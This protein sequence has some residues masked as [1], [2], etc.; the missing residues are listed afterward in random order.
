MADRGISTGWS[1]GTFRPSDSVSRLAMA[2]FMYRFAGSPAFTAPTTSPFNDIA[3][4]ST[5][6][7]E[8]AWV[9]STGISTG[10]ADGGYHPAENVSRQAMAAF[11][12]R[13][14]GVLA[15]A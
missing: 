7:A 8:V 12:H 4:G 6:Y 1:D 9:A 11:M 2:A 14:N 15:P 5:F 3:T 10:N 13:L